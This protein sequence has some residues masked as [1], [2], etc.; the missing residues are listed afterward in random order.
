MAF[1]RW[2]QDV[3]SNDYII[4]DPL[5]VSQAMSLQHNPRTGKMEAP[6]GSFDD[7]LNCAVI[8]NYVRPEVTASGAFTTEDWD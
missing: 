2:G 6:R 3:T 5:V 1:N 4:N 8:V 7:M